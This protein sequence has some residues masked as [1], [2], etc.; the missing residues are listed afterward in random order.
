[1]KKG[2]YVSNFI[3]IAVGIALMIFIPIDN[4]FSPSFPN[5]IIATFLYTFPFF[6]AIPVVTLINETY[7]MKKLSE[8]E[9]IKRRIALFEKINYWYIAPLMGPTIIFFALLLYVMPPMLPIALVIGSTF[10]SF[11]IYKINMNARKK[12]LIL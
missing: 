11:F 8:R 6:I 10:F 5:H 4:Y 1:M 9:V 7:K 2:I 12:L 3:E